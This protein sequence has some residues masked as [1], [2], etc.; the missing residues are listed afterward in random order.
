[1]TPERLKELKEKLHHC[2]VPR[3]PR[4]P[5]DPGISCH[6]HSLC[7]CEV[8]ELFIYIDRLKEKLAGVEKVAVSQL[9]LGLDFYHLDTESWVKKYGPGLTTKALGN[10]FRDALK[11]I[12]G[13][14]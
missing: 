2:L 10:K 4:D 7:G 3:D 9:Q 14:I 5:R 6:A 8:E 12:Q 11:T 13:E 1:M